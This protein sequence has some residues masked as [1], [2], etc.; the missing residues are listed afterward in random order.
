MKIYVK[1]QEKL[2]NEELRPRFGIALIEDRTSLLR[3]EQQND[4]IFF[5]FYEK[6]PECPVLYTGMNGI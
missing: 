3:S 4:K 1:S 5:S 6:K 2:S